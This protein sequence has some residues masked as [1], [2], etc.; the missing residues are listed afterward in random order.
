M[1]LRRPVLRKGFAFPGRASNVVLR[2]RLRLKRRGAASPKPFGGMS[3]CPER[4]SLS[5]RQGGRAAKAAGW[6]RLLVF[7]VC[8]CPEGTGL[9][10]P[11]SPVDPCGAR[12]RHSSCNTASLT[13]A[14]PQAN[15]PARAAFDCR[16]STVDCLTSLRL[17]QQNNEF[18]LGIGDVAGDVGGDVASPLHGFPG[19][20]GLIEAE[21]LVVELDGDGPRGRR[22]V[23]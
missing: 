12:T 21:I 16:L 19:G 6:R 1:R 8:R 7:G 9:C 2:L 13:T 14:D 4:Q 22:D 5:A 11:L 23:G 20:A 3:A 10:C 18:Q 15:S 17:R